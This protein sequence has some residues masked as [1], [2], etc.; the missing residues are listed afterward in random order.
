MLI[1]A[2]AQKRCGPN[3]VLRGKI[4]IKMAGFGGSLVSNILQKASVLDERFVD[5]NLNVRY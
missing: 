1:N 5:D 3:D 2:H 4:R